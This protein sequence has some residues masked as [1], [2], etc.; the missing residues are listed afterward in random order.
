MIRQTK[1]QKLESKVDAIRNQS[2]DGLGD[3][4]EQFASSLVKLELS[5]MLTR[6]HRMQNEIDEKKRRIETLEQYAKLQANNN[7]KGKSVAKTSRSNQDQA[8]NDTVDSF[9]SSY[10]TNKE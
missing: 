1:V 3:I 9:I 8:Y 6:I 7:K 4:Q 10:L 2:E 5:N